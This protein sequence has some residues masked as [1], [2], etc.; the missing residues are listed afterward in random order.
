MVAELCHRCRDIR[1]ATVS[2][3]LQYHHVYFVPV[4]KKKSMG[5]EVVCSGCRC[6]ILAKQ[7]AYIGFAAQDPGD[8][9]T[10]VEMTNPGAVE[11]LAARIELD[12]RI[13]A[14]TA[15]RA[16]RITAIN[17]ACM[18]AGLPHQV[19]LHGVFPTTALCLI[20]V[21]IFGAAWAIA[22]NVPKPDPSLVYSLAVGTVLS[23]L[24]FIYSAATVKGRFV[25]KKIMP[26]LAAELAAIQPT[27]SELT[28]SR[29][30]LKKNKLSLANYLRPEAVV[31]AVRE[32]HPASGPLT[33]A[34]L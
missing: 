34:Q 8:I 2:E 32:A 24:F 13:A 10:L 18:A 5:F 16:D 4:G 25:R 21:P 20:G 6:M 26:G 1:P 27:V 33:P 14:G 19:R 23:L 15:S 9:G 3:M 28:E 17:E 31:A 30:I 11:R 29:E 12:E 7:H 22:A